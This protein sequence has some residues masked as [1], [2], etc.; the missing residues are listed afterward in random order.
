MSTTP[1]LTVEAAAD[2]LSA[3]EEFLEKCEGNFAL[4]IDR[5]GTI[6]SQHGLIPETT[7]TTVLGALAAGSFAATHELALRVGETDCPALYQQGTRSHLLISTVTPDVVLVTVFGKQTT[8]GLVK[9]YSA[10]AI[11]RIAAVLTDLNTYRCQHAVFTERDLADA[12]NLFG[13]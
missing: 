12:V 11:K 1:I 9:F 13:R 7:D 3:L 4:I 5:G 10:R 2:L 8:V 6:L